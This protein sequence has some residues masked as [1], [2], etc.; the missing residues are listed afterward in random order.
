MRSF[1]SSYGLTVQKF[2]HLVVQ[3]FE[4]Q[5][6]SSL[7]FPALLSVLYDTKVQLDR[8]TKPK[9]P[10]QKNQI[11]KAPDEFST[12]LK[13]LRSCVPFT[14]S[15]GL[16]VR[17]FRHLTVKKFERQKSSSLDIS[18]LLCDATIQLDRKPKRQLE[19]F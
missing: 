17:K 15:H 10:N 7:H 19:G 1:T 5:K 11:L 18:A 12:C 9:K 14:P 8:K 2:R 3:K 16:T 13:F 6:S 4:R